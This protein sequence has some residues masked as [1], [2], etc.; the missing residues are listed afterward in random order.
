[1]NFV[2]TVASGVPEMHTIISMIGEP[3]IDHDAAGIDAIDAIDDYNL[4]Y[5]D[6]KII[7]ESSWVSRG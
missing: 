7:I 2:N 4:K 3:C 6:V 5:I 1:L